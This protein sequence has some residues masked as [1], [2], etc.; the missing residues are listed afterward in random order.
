MARY[1]IKPALKLTSKQWKKLLERVVL[2]QTS[3]GTE[4][5]LPAS[6]TKEAALEP[7]SLLSGRKKVPSELPLTS[8]EPTTSLPPEAMDV[9]S[10]AP[11]RQRVLGRLYEHESLG[12]G[13]EITRAKDYPWLDALNKYMQEPGKYTPEVKHRPPTDV[14]SFGAKTK[15]TPSGV[16][17]E[18][19]IFRPVKEPAERARRATIEAEAER[20]A[21]AKIQK[22]AISKYGAPIKKV[23]KLK[24]AEIPTEERLK[25]AAVLDQV[26]K[27]LGGKRTLTGRSWEMFRQSSRG[28]RK[29]PDA[30]EYFIRVG[31]RWMENPEA[32]AKIYPREVRSMRS[33]FKD[34]AEDIPSLERFLK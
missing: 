31:L 7:F 26:W 22:K 29:A 25:Q 10:R 32:A 17:Y 20:A 9:L 16:S 23:D 34:F 21:E 1:L 6:V 2:R 33:I 30:R 4:A 3:K 15:A 14:L 13:E 27:A 12:G 5:R 11:G 18:Q 28:R 19:K 24:V 8:G